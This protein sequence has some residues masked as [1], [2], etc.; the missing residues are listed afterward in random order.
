[1]TLTEILFV[2]APIVAAMIIALLVTF[3]I[4]RREYYWAVIP[5]ALI[6]IVALLVTS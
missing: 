4:L 3:R 2:V 1:M 6:A 5:F